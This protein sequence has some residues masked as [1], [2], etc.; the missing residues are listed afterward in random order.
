MPHSAHRSTDGEK[1]R[2]YDS[3]L[4]LG[5]DADTLRQSCA[6]EKWFILDHT[7]QLGVGHL[8]GKTNPLSPIGFAQENGDL[9]SFEEGHVVTGMA[10]GNPIEGLS[11][12]AVTA[13]RQ[14]THAKLE[15]MGKG[16]TL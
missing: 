13:H 7:T 5:E 1:P 9:G 3:D 10:L 16:R 6:L 4:A 2:P 15:M 8:I 11:G 12:F 14:V